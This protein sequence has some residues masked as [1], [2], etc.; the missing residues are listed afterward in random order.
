MTFKDN[1]DLSDTDLRHIR[2]GEGNKVAFWFV[3]AAVG[4]AIVAG[5]ISATSYF[6]TQSMAKA[7]AVTTGLSGR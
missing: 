5:G 2:A 1:R 4:A 6:G 7:A 3:L